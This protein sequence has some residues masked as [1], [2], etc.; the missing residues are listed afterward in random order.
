M[1]DEIDTRKVALDERRLDFEIRKYEDDKGLRAL[2]LEKAKEDL[3]KVKEDIKAAQRPFYLNPS[4]LTP[5]A[6]IC[7]AL[8]GGFFAFG[9]NWLNSDVLKLKADR[10][11]LLVT[12]DSLT[13][14]NATLPT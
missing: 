5:L 7:V 8:L 14:T 2:S 1:S 4:Y 9:T 12:R 3:N 10:D 11:G 13:S 6:T